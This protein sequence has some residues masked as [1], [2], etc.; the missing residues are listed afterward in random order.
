MT[1]ASAF[2]RRADAA[3]DV[4]SHGLPLARGTR[5]SDAS[6]VAGPRYR[7]LGQRC[8][9]R[10]EGLGAWNVAKRGH[11]VTSSSNREAAADDRRPEG[12]PNRGS[13][14]RNPAAVPGTGR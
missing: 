2:L 13:G 6:A 7:K 5:Q 12:A 11:S 4:P 1:T 8:V 3:A 14:N 10:R 9:D